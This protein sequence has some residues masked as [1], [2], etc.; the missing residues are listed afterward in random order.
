MTTFIQVNLNR[1]RIAQDLL[2]HQAEELRAAVCV[3]SEPARA[4]SSQQWFSSYNGLAAVHINPRIADF[5]AVLVAKGQNSV[6]VK[7]GSTYIVSC[8]VSPNINRAGYSN[9]LDELSNLCLSAVNNRI[10]ICGDFNAHARLWG[11]AATDFKGDLLEEWSAHM[12]FR[13][14]NV[15]NRPT[16]VGH[17]GQFIID[18]TWASSDLSA[19]VRDWSIRDD[20]ASLSDHLYITFSVSESIARPYKPLQPT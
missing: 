5:P 17:Q 10:L 3:V 19:R 8:Y 12:D 9:F 16:F 6:V 1:S 2:L 11:S 15:G 4:P 20:I 13:L 18:L 7:F 14:L